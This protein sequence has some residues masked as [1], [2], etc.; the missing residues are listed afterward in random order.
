MSKI[1]TEDCRRFMVEQATSGLLVP[2]FATRPEWEPEL[3]ARMDAARADAAI[4]AKWK[5]MGKM[6]IKTYLE[7][8]GSAVE[9]DEL[10]TIEAEGYGK[11]KAANVVCVR[12]MALDPVK[13][14][15]TY[16]WDVYE[17]TDGKLVLGLDSGD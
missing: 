3:Q 12:A 15:T 1:T 16:I 8:E 9:G 6:S 10:D 4:P 2:Y 17:T 7:W 5:R 11:I 13:H 14:D